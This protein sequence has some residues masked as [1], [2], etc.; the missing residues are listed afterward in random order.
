MSTLSK[1]SW[2]TNYPGSEK[3]A[4]IIGEF[5]LL[6]MAE[7]ITSPGHF[8]LYTYRCF[9]AL[10]LRCCNGSPVVL[11]SDFILYYFFF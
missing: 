9:K 1:P 10:D 3:C 5:T 11:F 6:I 8:R 2:G 4:G 7:G